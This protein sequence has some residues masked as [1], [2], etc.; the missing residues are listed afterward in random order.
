MGR[1]TGLGVA[2]VGVDGGKREGWE[3]DDGGVGSEECSKTHEGLT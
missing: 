1:L 3:E 2:P